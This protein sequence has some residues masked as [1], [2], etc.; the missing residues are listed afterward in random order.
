M[1][2]R[3]VPLRNLIALVGLLFL[4]DSCGSSPSGCGVC[5]TQQNAPTFTAMFSAA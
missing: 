2:T 3:I 1:K 4:L 5:G